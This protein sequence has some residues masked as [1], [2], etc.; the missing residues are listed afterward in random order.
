M[1]SEEPRTF[2]LFGKKITI[3]ALLTSL[4]LL[5]IGTNLYSI[6]RTSWYPEQ[7]RDNV[8]LTQNAFQNL[9]AEFDEILSEDS[10]DEKS[11][12]EL[13]IWVE[14][15]SIHSATVTFLDKY[16]FDLWD[17]TSDALELFEDFLEELRDTTTLLSDENR[18][19][20]LDQDSNEKL[21]KLQDSLKEFYEHVFP[22]DVQEEGTIWQTPHYGEMDR[23]RG[24]LIRFK[25]DVARAWLILPV[26]SGSATNPPEVQARELLVEAVGEEYVTEYFEFEGVQFNYWEPEDWLASVNYYYKIR[27]GNYTVSREVYVRFSKMNEYLSSTGVPVK[28]N[29]MPFN[30]TKERAVD[31]ALGNVERE[32]VEMEAEMYYVKRLLN[33]T[34][35]GRYLWSVHFYHTKKYSM[36]GSATRVIINP[37]SGQVIEAEEY[38][39]TA[40]S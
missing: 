12:R 17:D 35:I 39:W 13:E 1:T 22:Y 24:K 2:T 5:L 15:T 36:K 26:I 21:T 11:I 4:V 33:G 38:G 31:I 30:V 6:S 27:V 3:T 19:I 25:Q 9:F 18:T 8:A 29:L 34:S 14:K 16:H 37:I 40:V 23:A 10:L 32:F 7:F 20:K 28:D